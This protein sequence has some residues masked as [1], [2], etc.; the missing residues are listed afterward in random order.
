MFV[1]RRIG[2][3]SGDDVTLLIQWDKRIQ[4]IRRQQRFSW[5]VVRLELG[6]WWCTSCAMHSIESSTMRK[7]D[8]PEHSRAL[9]L[10]CCH[11]IVHRRDLIRSIV[12]VTIVR[13]DI[14]AMLEDHFHDHSM[15]CQLRR[16]K[17]IFSTSLGALNRLFSRASPRHPFAR[18]ERR[19][20]P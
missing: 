3:L 2:E 6:V 1:V 17:S 13:I 12:S 4:Q 7:K 9:L 14:C 11:A 16:N 15:L 10:R 20:L 18:G 5:D 8:L 19:S